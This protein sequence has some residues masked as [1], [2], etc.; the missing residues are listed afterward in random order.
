M[1]T[2][3]RA[4]V[5]VLAGTVA[6][7]GLAADGAYSRAKPKPTPQPLWDLYPLD[8]TRG[9]ARERASRPTR[10]RPGAGGVAGKSATVPVKLEPGAANESSGGGSSFSFALLVGAFAAAIILLALAALPRNAVPRLSEKVAE[11]RLDVAL[12]GALAL[13]VLATIYFAGSF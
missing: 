4:S 10:S 5:C 2:L 7:L 6:M 13:V 12:A 11:H 1:T 8:P 3:R 9:D